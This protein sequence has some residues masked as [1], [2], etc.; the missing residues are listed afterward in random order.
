MSNGGIS[1]LLSYS[2]KNILGLTNKENILDKNNYLEDNNNI[3]IFD[4][5]ID[6]LNNLEIK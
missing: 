3:K 1:E 6:F 4:N 2:S 5:Y